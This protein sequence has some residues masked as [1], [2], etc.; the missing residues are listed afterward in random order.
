MLDDARLKLFQSKPLLIRQQLKFQLYYHWLL[1][2]H[3][4]TKT[5]FFVVLFQIVAYSVPHLLKV[6]A[7][8]CGSDNCGYRKF[9]N[10]FI[11]GLFKGAFICTGLLTNRNTDCFIYFSI[12]FNRNHLIQ[13]GIVQRMIREY[14]LL[15]DGLSVA[16]INFT[17]WSVSR[18]RLMESDYR[19][20]QQSG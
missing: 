18:L 9:R 15:S 20:L 4:P 5:N 17:L 10:R 12:I 3:S 1:W 7:T 11:Q 6:S 8:L 14:I 16:N 13:I 2:V 19:R